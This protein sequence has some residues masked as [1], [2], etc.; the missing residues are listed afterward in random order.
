MLKVNITKVNNYLETKYPNFCTFLS[1][2]VVSN[3]GHV[4]RLAVQEKYI[5]YRNKGLNITDSLISIACDFDSEY[6]TIANY[7]KSSVK[8]YK[9][10]KKVKPH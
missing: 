9:N 4:V 10:S 6:E 3:C 1:L 7:H 2:G 8:L 5:E